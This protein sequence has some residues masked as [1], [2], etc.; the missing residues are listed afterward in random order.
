MN[1]QGPPRTP[2]VGA[3]L[4]GL[5]L[6]ALAVAVGAHEVLGRSWDW[7]GTPPGSCCCPVWPS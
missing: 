1:E 6:L 5:V 2:D 4:G 7:R 3:V